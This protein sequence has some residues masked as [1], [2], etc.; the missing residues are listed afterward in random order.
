MRVR[1]GRAAPAS[2]VWPDDAITAEWLAG[3][4]A[5]RRAADAAPDPWDDPAG[6]PQP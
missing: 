3:I 5:A 2:P 1:I 6:A 4:A